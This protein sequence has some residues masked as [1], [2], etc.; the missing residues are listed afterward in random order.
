VFSAGASLYGVAD[1][2]LLAQET[3][4]F[5][6]RYLD[7]LIGPYPEKKQIY[8]ER[9]PI[10]SVDKFT[11]PVILFQVNDTQDHISNI[12]NLIS[13]FKLV[14]LNRYVEHFP[15]DLLK[16]KTT[17]KPLISPIMFWSMF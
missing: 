1:C 2:E 12:F 9:S 6:S 5:E 4:K 16:L 8:I 10:H 7:N 11:A 15:I 3:H 13:S 14:F 17:Y